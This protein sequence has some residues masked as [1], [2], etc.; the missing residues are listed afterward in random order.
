VPRIYDP[1]L[2]GRRRLLSRCLHAVA[3]G[4]GTGDVGT[5]V[6]PGLGPPDT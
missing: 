2:A 6:R 5:L 4:Y 1:Q 3:C